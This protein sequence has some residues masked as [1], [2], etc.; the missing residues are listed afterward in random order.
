L[1]TL[2]DR[3]GVDKM[4]LALLLQVKSSLGIATVYMKQ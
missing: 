2:F 4:A 1:H 3:A